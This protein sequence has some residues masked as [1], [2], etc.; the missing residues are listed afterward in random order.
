[1]EN[2][3]NVTYIAGGV[4]AKEWRALRAGNYIEQHKHTFDHLSY[5][6]SGSVEVEVEGQKTIY[7]GPTGINIRAN[8]SHKVLALTDNVLWLCI[9]AVPDELRDAALIEKALIQ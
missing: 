2:Q 6:A 7:H 3:L 5:L 4:Y 1:M 8:A 9:H